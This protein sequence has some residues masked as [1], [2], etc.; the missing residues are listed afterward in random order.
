MKNYQ[1]F[2]DGNN[3]ANT[4]GRS[5]RV[6]LDAPANMRH[7]GSRCWGISQETK[8]HRRPSKEN[9]LQVLLHPKGLH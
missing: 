9:L 6:A 5:V 2:Q 1:E 3:R 7:R 8:A 4:G